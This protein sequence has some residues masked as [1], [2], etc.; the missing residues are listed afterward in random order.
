[1][2]R[3]DYE[4]HG[5]SK[6][7]QYFAWDNMVAR[8]TNPKHPYFKWYGARGITVAPVWMTFM[9][10]W[11]DMEDGYARGLELDRIDNE[12]GYE[13]G[14]CRWVTRKQN[15]R[16]RRNTVRIDTPWGEIPVSEAVER[17]GLRY[18]TIMGRIKAGWDP[19]DAVTIPPL[20]PGQRKNSK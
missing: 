19:H 9:G 16:N 14:N 3:R 13:P 6:T 4:Q 18:N 15:Q 2:R 1:M 12:R 17:T 8:C 7:P 10:F 5:M 20:Q 11:R